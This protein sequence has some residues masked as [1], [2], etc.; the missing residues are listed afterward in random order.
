MIRLATP[1]DAGAL[2]A[3]LVRCSPATRYRRFH[4]VV[5]EFPPAYLRRCLDGEHTAMVAEEA[6]EVVAL[7]SVGPV[8]EEPAVHEVAV[9]VE[10]RWQSKGLGRELVATLLAHAGVAVVRMELCRT[11]LLDYV[12]ATLPVLA[13][14][15]HGCDTTIDVDVSSAVQQWRELGRDRGER[16]D[17]LPQPG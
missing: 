16:A 15:D 4:G 1:R 12:T 2:A 14:H 11:P 17:V 13:S 7:A 8:F 6:G 9:I 5:A 3:M 10:D